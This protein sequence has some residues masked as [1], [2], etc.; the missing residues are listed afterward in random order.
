M[1]LVLRRESGSGRRRR[2]WRKQLWGTRSIG[3]ES[4]VGPGDA[5]L[6]RNVAD[7]HALD[8]SEKQKVRFLLLQNGDDPIRSL[9]RDSFGVGPIG[10]VPDSIRPLRTPKGTKWVPFITF[11]QTF[12]DM[13]NALTPTPGVF[14]EGGHDYRLEIPEAIR[15][16]W[17]LDIADDKMARVQEAL[18][19]QELHWEAA[20][21]WEAAEAITDDEKRKKAE[22]KA[23]KQIGKWLGNEPGQDITP[24]QIA[25][26]SSTD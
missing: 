1:G 7:W 21:A 12:I 20:R 26:L 22:E 8:E 10:S 4:T 2:P 23:K 13:L 11:V 18:R 15:K 14:A 5:Y 19:T 3:D 16:V 25:R 6:P 17:R 24:E 9:G